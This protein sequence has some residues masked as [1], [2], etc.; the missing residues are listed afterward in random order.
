[1]RIRR[2]VSETVVLAPSGELDL[3]VAPE[4]RAR[5]SAAHRDG[6]RVVLDLQDVVFIDSSALSVVLWAERR[7]RVT[8][9]SLR[10]VQPAE[11]VL[12]ILRICGLADRLM[13]R[14]Q[15]RLS[16]STGL[17]GEEVW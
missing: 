17:V 1:M 9:G 4:L 6:A 16:T 2:S 15:R 8:G 14:H 10:L 3:A 13:G 11:G 5:L 7:L 12:R